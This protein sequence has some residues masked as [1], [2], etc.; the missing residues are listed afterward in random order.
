MSLGTKL[1]HGVVN[2]VALSDSFGEGHPEL[3]FKGIAFSQLES[4]KSIV[5]KPTILLFRLMLSLTTS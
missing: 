5:S 2:V 3:R 1:V 4:L